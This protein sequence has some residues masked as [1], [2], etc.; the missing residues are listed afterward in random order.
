MKINTEEILRS[1]WFLFLSIVIIL[2][3]FWALGKMAW[4]NYQVN[5]QI[6]NLESEVAQIENDNQKLSDLI[7]YFQ[8]ETFKEQE[9]R[10]KLGLVMPGEKVLVFPGNDKNTENGIVETVTKQN[11]E[12]SEPNYKKWWSFFFADK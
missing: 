1:R 5:Q 7:A 9:A 4:Q 3:F 11:N 6:K 12:V 2:Y 10:E 8:T